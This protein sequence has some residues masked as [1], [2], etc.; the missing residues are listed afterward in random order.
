MSLDK[1]SQYYLTVQRSHESN[2]WA[3]YKTESEQ[4]AL[5]LLALFKR[6]YGQAQKGKPRLQF[7]VVSD[8]DLSIEDRVLLS[9]AV[10]NVRADAEEAHCCTDG[11]RYP[12]GTRGV[13]A[14]WYDRAC[15]WDKQLCMPHT[16]VEAD[17]KANAPEQDEGEANRRIKTR[18]K[19]GKKVWGAI[20][21]IA[22][23]LGAVGT[24]YFGILDRWFP[25]EQ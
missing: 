25:R 24:W 3:F 1:R 20:I 7:E 9:E 17:L 4:V 5:N 15:K 23:I 16:T 12:R 21:V 19:R 18:S 8:A 11:P 6:E 10:E 22:A 14:Q 13:L 2:R